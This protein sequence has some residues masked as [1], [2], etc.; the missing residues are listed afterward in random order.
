MPPLILSARAR[1]PEK[2]AK[3]IL[4]SYSERLPPK[5]AAD[6]C[7]LSLNSIYLQYNRIRWRLILARYYQNGALS[8]DEE[9]LAPELKI[10][11]RQRRGISEEDIYPHAAELIEW[12]EK[13]PPRLVLKY[14]NKIFA[15][16]GPLDIKP[17][18]NELQQ[19]R[20]FAYVRFAR[21]ELIYERRKTVPVIDEAQQDLIN[22]A[23]NSLDTVRLAYRAASKKLERATR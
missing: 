6:V 20:L 2:T 23:K 22:R 4:N 3:K 21:V 16:T 8:F 9:G 5:E 14:L 15:L 7:D 10:Q 12:A 1:I 19:V 18:L 17:D 13:W 11:L